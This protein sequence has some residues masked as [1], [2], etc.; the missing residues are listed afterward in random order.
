MGLVTFVISCANSCLNR[1]FF[2]DKQIHISYDMNV[3][4][5][6]IDNVHI[7]VSSHDLGMGT[8]ISW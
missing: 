6:V 5:T 7:M 1:G 4:D 8:I 3:I 2:I